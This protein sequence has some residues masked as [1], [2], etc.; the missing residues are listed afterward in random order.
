MT[1]APQMSVVRVL[2]RKPWRGATP[3]GR[4]GKL[5]LT[6]LDPLGWA[7]NGRITTP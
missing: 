7:T 1:T 2:A 4:P 5:W 6:P 3:S